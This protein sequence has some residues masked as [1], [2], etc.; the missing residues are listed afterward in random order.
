[1]AEDVESPFLPEMKRLA[2]MLSLRLPD[3]FEW[4]ADV[5]A[6]ASALAR[7][8]GLDADAARRLAAASS[9][10]DV[11]LIAIHDAVLMKP[12]PLTADEWDHVKGHPAAGREMLTGTGDSLGELAAAVAGGHHE[13]WAGTGYPQG[14]SGS[15]IPFE[16]RIVAVASAFSAMCSARPFRRAVTRHEAVAQL[17]DGSGQQFDPALVSLFP[18]VL[19]NL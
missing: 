9:V 8:A 1:M 16:A 2:A 17:Q 7:A 14:L 5:R 19:T 4:P 3:E 11:G 6:L 15:E 12:G 13:H 10:C 18:G